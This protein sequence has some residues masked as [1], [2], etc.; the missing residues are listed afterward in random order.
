MIDLNLLKYLSFSFKYFKIKHA[1]KVS[2]IDPSKFH[3][4]CGIGF[5][6]TAPGRKRKEYCLLHYR[7]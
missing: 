4:A 6:A 7:H 1:K 2:L 5:I 3:D